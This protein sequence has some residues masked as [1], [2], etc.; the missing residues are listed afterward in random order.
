MHN[1]M[2]YNIALTIM[3]DGSRYAGWQRLRGEHEP[4][5]IQGILEEHLEQ[6]IK[7]ET[8]LIGSGRTDAGVHAFGQVANFHMSKDIVVDELKIKLNKSLPE[9]IRI[10]KVFSVANEF[11]SRYDA[12]AK[13]YEYCIDTREV[14]SVFKRKYSYHHAEP[15]NVRSMREATRYLIGEHDFTSFSSNMRDNRS[16]VRTLYEIN[17]LEEKDKI[18][19]S[20]RGNGFL[21]N[22][23]R[24]IVGTLLE[25]GEGKRKPTDMEGIISGLDRQLAGPTISSHALA[26]KIVYY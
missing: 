26:L 17:I 13:T 4:L 19:I 10:I 14:P 23:V 1:N 24:I 5:T 6:I 12:I 9:D 21:Y 7:E 3:Y 20:L 2:K 8:K 25:V 22:M 15:L 18:I 11:H 16:T